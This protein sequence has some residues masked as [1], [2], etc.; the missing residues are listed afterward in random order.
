MG[1]NRVTRTGLPIRG[2]IAIFSIFAAAGAAQP[3]DSVP[4]K[5]LLQYVQKARRSGVNDDAI[6]QQAVL[7]GW[8]V[9]AV[10]RAIAYDQNEKPAKLAEPEPEPVP[11]SKNPVPAAPVQPAP[12]ADPAIKAGGTITSASLP[13]GIETPQDYQIAAGDTLQVSVW[14]E[15]DVSVPS[16]IVRP[17]GKISV[18]LI[19]DI[20]VAGLTP[21]DV[22]KRITDQLTKF[23]TDANVTVVV[24]A[25]APKKIYVTGGAKKEGPVPFT[26]GM[27]VMQAISE[28]G[29]L[30]DYAKRKKIYILHSEN[31][32]E[33]RLDFNYD[34]VLR[35]VRMEQNVA[36][37]PNDTVVIPN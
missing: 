34:E 17:D 1:L 2:V 21:K 24:T 11:P 8:P 29:G 12:P 22:E 15:P 14:K 31:G 18:P 6:K 26:Y 32:R 5:E 13:P 28:A 9:G 20:E 23:Y 3:A 25:M 37:S 4:P 16:E 35:G 7:V 27:R 33:Y 19:K 10:D 30:T 36:L